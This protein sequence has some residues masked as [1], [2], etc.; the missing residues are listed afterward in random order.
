MPGYSMTSGGEKIPFMPEE[1]SGQRRPIEGTDR[2]H[3]RVYATMIVRKGLPFVNGAHWGLLLCT[4]FFALLRRRWYLTASL[5][6]EVT[7]IKVP[8]YATAWVLRFSTL[9]FVFSLRGCRHLSRHLEGCPHNMECFP[10]RLRHALL[11]GFSAVRSLVQILVAVSLTGETYFWALTPTYQ[12]DAVALDLQTIF[13]PE[14]P[15]WLSFF[16]VL[17]LIVNFTAFAYSVA[18]TAITALYLYVWVS[19]LI[20]GSQKAGAEKALEEGRPDTI[21]E[22]AGNREFRV[23]ITEYLEEE[24]DIV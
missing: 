19:G 1:T 8:P 24:I 2:P 4:S 17:L 18:V 14:V 5:G 9:L 15:P 12:R 16:S 21:A 11:N 23:E 13:N 3:P 20:S 22:N 6:Q 10:E 7:P